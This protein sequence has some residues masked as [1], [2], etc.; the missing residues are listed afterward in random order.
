MNVVS[1]TVE[2]YTCDLK[3]VKH[4]YQWV[5]KSQGQYKIEVV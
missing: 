2:S 5:D 3:Q 1:R 4:G